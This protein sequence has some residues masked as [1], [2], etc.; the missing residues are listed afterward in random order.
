MV[1]VAEAYL[2][3]ITEVR[4]NFKFTVEEV[5]SETEGEVALITEGEVALITEVEVTSEG[6]EALIVIPNQEVVSEKEGFIIP[7]S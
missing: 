2:M 1:A 5:A 4:R 6:V 3:E 7:M